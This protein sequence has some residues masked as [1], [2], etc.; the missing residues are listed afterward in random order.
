MHA[1][2]V[3]LVRCVCVRARERLLARPSCTA[4]S[5]LRLSLRRHYGAPAFPCESKLEEQLPALIKYAAVS[6]TQPPE[7]H[8]QS[9]VL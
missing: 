9:R 4:S 5:A 3:E 2:R 8:L 1:E 6:K 7:F